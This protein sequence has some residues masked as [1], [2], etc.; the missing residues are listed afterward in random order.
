MRS[1]GSWTEID[2]TLRRLPLKIRC[3]V[4]SCLTQEN[5]CC[6]NCQ[7]T[8]LAGNF[9]AQIRLPDRHFGQFRAIGPM[10]LLRRNSN[11]ILT[12]AHKGTRYS[13]SRRLKNVM[14]H[15]DYFFQVFTNCW[16]QLVFLTQQ[17]LWLFNN[18]NAV[19][20]PKGVN[21]FRL[22]TSLPASF[23]ASARGKYY[24]NNSFNDQM[25]LTRGRAIKG[26][27]SSLWQTNICLILLNNDIYD[28]IKFSH[29]MCDFIWWQKVVLF[30]CTVG[31]VFVIRRD[32]T[33]WRLQIETFPAFLALCEGNPPVTCGFPS[34]RPVTQSFDVFLCAPE[35]M[36]EQTV[37]ML[38]IW[39]AMALI[40]TSL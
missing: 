28:G 27:I 20:F 40:M 7:N 21:H 37:D 11:P 5:V 33:W 26:Q 36:A 4:S 30:F 17:V 10:E 38:V 9:G 18:C 15:L 13:Y 22:G 1:L 39:D 24:R 12:L 2:W 19:Y 23:R 29:A 31:R 14:V 16:S 3:A 34:Q 32:L 25:P 35:Q 8:S 6:P